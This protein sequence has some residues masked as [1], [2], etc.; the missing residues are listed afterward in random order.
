MCGMLAGRTRLDRFGGT[1]T[2]AHKDSY[3]LWT[4][5][6][7]IGSMRHDRSFIELSTTEKCETQLFWYL[8]ISKIYLMQWNPTRFKRSLDSRASVIEIGM[9]SRVVQRVEMVCTRVSHGLQAT[10][11]SYE[12]KLKFFQTHSPRHTSPHNQPT[13]IQ[14]S[15]PLH[16]VLRLKKKH[17]ESSHCTQLRNV[18]NDF[19]TNRSS[20]KSQLV[21]NRSSLKLEC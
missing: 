13:A 21:R 10:T 4:V 7:E 14:P 16:Q 8:Q 2:Q 17:Q 5:L 20:H 11:Q 9:F 12:N 15:S 18:R 19:N 6:I 3:L 1:T